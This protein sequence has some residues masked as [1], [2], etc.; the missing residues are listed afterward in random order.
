MN[1]STAACTAVKIRRNIH[2]QVGAH[3]VIP[4]STGLSGG[5]HI[6]LFKVE[7]SWYVRAKSD[8]HSACFG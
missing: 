5:S 1:T 2:A 7:P 8:F 3:S 6:N 4:E